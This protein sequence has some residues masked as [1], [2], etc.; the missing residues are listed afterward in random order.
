MI[1]TPRQAYEL[2]QEYNQGNSTS[3]TAASWEM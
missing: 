2:L 1:P 3:S